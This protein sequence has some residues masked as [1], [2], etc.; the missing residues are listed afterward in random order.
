MWKLD[1]PTGQ[2][3]QLTS[4]PIPHGFASLSPD[5]QWV[6]VQHILRG[7]AQVWILPAAGGKM[8]PLIDSPG[9]WY[10]GGWSEDGKELVVAGNTGNG[11]ALHAVSRETR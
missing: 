1:L 2:R 8:T 10:A 6:Q 5:G 11:W 9:I 3:T 4:G 7:A